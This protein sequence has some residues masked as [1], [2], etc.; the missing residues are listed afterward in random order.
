MKRSELPSV[1]H[2]WTYAFEFSKPG[3]KISK[4]GQQTAIDFWWNASE[5]TLEYIIGTAAY[6]LHRNAPATPPIIWPPKEYA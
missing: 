1:A 2:F 4:W 6:R 5:A 3:S